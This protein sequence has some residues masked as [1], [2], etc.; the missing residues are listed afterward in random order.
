MRRGSGPAAGQDD[1]EESRDEM[2]ATATENT[3]R[4]VDE[5]AMVEDWIR[6]RLTQAGFSDNDATVVIAARLDWRML[7]RL[8]ERGCPRH[9]ALAIVR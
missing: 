2:W 8:R 6:E 4:A 5:A 3:S 7:V 1:H 9:L